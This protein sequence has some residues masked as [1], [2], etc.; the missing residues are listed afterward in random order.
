[1]GSLHDGCKLAVNLCRFHGSRL[2]IRTIPEVLPHVRFVL[3]VSLNAQ[4]ETRFMLVCS[5]SR[6]AVDAA[7]SN[8]AR[9]KLLLLMKSFNAGRSF[10]DL[11]IIGTHTN[12]N[13]CM[14]V[15]D[16][17]GLFWFPR[18]VLSLSDPLRRI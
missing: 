18:T 16:V 11:H 5:N 6:R 7:I 8:S 3:R 15:S 4:E 17:A 9:Q 14:S 10:R 2:S 13:C 12:A 1:M